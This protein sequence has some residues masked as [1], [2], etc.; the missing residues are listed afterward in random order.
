MS[1]LPSF[2]EAFSGTFASEPAETV[3]IDSHE[4]SVQTDE[5]PEEDVVEEIIE[6]G[7]DTEEDAE[8]LEEAEDA[9]PTEGE[10][11]EDSETTE[12]KSEEPV[13]KPRL[14]VDDIEFD[15]D[16]VR[17]LKQNYERQEGL[18]KQHQSFVKRVQDVSKMA[19]EKPL[20][21]VDAILNQLVEFN[22]EINANMFY[23]ALTYKMLPAIEELASVEPEQRQ[24]L[25]I[26]HENEILKQKQQ[27]QLQQKQMAEQQKE[28]QSGV[29]TLMERYKTDADSLNQA[30]ERIKDR[31][32]VLKADS[33]QQLQLLETEILRHSFETEARNVLKSVKSDKLD[34]V[35][36]LNDLIIFQAKQKAPK[37]EAE[38]KANLK[39]LKERAQK[40]YGKETKKKPKKTTK[41]KDDSKQEASLKSSDFSNLDLFEQFGM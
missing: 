36:A 33:K 1:D 2:E 35:E 19:V 16:A 13:E 37:N 34:D 27:V 3:T 17:N 7:E 39:A 10:D 11:V 9:E 28:L 30:W 6:D 4:E 5:S 24:A 21:A 22:P 15:E 32:D 18:L 25:L 26:Q 12:E 41:P 31:D 38:E 40:L 23:K 14:K 8:E 20:D 29:E